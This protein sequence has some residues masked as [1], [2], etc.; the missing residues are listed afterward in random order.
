M[1]SRY[2]HELD[3]MRKAS[4]RPSPSSSLEHSTTKSSSCSPLSTDTRTHIHSP[5]HSASKVKLAY[6][7]RSDGGGWLES[8]PVQLPATTSHSSPQQS[9]QQ[10]DCF[11]TREGSTKDLLGTVSNNDI[12]KLTQLTNKL[13]VVSKKRNHIPKGHKQTRHRQYMEDDEFLQHQEGPSDISNNHRHSDTGLTNLLNQDFMRA[14][15]VSDTDYSDSALLR[16]PSCNTSTVSTDTDDSQFSWHNTNSR[17][18]KQSPALARIPS[19]QTSR[20]IAAEKA[21]SYHPLTVSTTAP[22]LESDLTPSSSQ[23]S[24]NSKRRSWYKSF[25]KRDKKGKFKGGDSPIISVDEP[26]LDT[27]YNTDEPRSSNI[28][29]KPTI[30]QSN[31]ECHNL[32]SRTHPN[33][34][35]TTN[36]LIP[37]S[38]SA[39]SARTKL[40]FSTRRKRQS[41]FGIRNGPPSDNTTPSQDNQIHRQKLY[42]RR[43]SF[44]NIRDYGLSS[45]GSNSPLDLTTT[46]A[47]N[48]GKDHSDFTSSN[49][50]LNNHDITT[51]GTTTSQMS[52]T[53][54]I[55][56][57]TVSFST[58]SPPQPH[59]PSSNIPPLDASTNGN[60]SPR[61]KNKNN[62]SMVAL[63][64][65]KKDA[66][67]LN[68]ND[69]EIDRHAIGTILQQPVIEITPSMLQQEENQPNLSPKRIFYF[70]YDSLP[71]ENM[72]GEPQGVKALVKR[73]VDNGY[74]TMAETQ[75][76]L[77]GGH[78]ED[79]HDYDDDDDDDDLISTLDES[80][81]D[82]NVVDKEAGGNGGNNHIHKT[83]GGKDHDGAIRT[84][85]SSKVIG[86]DAYYSWVN[87]RR[88][89]NVNIG[90]RCIAEICIAVENDTGFYKLSQLAEE[91]MLIKGRLLN[92]FVSF[93]VPDKLDNDIAPNLQE[94]SILSILNERAQG[95]RD[96]VPM[97]ESINNTQHQQQ[98][99]GL[100]HGSRKN[101]DSSS[102]T[103]INCTNNSSCSLSS[104][105]SIASILSSSASKKQQSV[106]SATATA[107]T[108]RPLSSF[109]SNKPSSTF[110]Q[111]LWSYSHS[112]EST[113]YEYRQNQLRNAVS[114][115]RRG[116]DEFKRSLE[117]TES[118]IHSVKI[119]MNDTKAK[120]DIYFKDVPETHYSELKRLEVSI[121]S[122]LANRAKSRGVELLYW[123]LTALLTGCA[124]LLWAIIW[125]LRL[126][127]TI[128]SFPGKMIKTFNEHMEERNKV[129]KQAGMRVVAKG[130]DRPSMPSMD[131]PR[132]PSHATIDA[133]VDTPSMDVH[134]GL[135]SP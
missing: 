80:L 119:D 106:G 24:R 38:S 67:D 7:D 63:G 12:L 104:F 121:E 114:D 72:H 74:G 35:T 97:N 95:Y 1:H 54:P 9:S 81:N 99:P 77:D 17:H 109:H 89:S 102:E 57:S 64:T 34:D 127:Q 73:M 125:I 113:T 3:H 86:G 82:D 31:T 126:G 85:E 5:A 45:H 40:R 20:T 13:P 112:R 124:F 116:M 130:V 33:V 108:T 66:N 118:M 41:S 79:D 52:S 61:D 75:I 11:A 103:D 93:L 25:M 2:Y 60:D 37:P 27:G 8:S 48:K 58:S 87:N 123:L 111:S 115:L 96:F 50:Y 84:I 49:V 135:N 28:A 4:K 101:S 83:V 19:D 107:P 51:S 16:V 18:P 36:Y 62:N 10:N 21:R 94:N 22:Y 98:R 117:N 65:P 47:G 30:F 110:L 32:R 131:Q 100:Y 42:V 44:D 133:E 71:W 92:L 46:P 90:S 91:T 70:D 128:I 88:S 15:P 69:N 55:A 14:S 29:H 26:D 68:P 78:D 105:S 56:S 122:I 23:Y 132:S 120:M 39:T 59:I 6:F 53:S 129:V 43:H 134:R 76:I